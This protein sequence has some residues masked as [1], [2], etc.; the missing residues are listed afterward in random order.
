VQAR[1]PVQPTTPMTPD[2][3]DGSFASAKRAAAIAANRSP[4]DPGQSPA[5]AEKRA[6][7]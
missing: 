2:H 4:I 7:A 1:D 6:T 5:V 3:R